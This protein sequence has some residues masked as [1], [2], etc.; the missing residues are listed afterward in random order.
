MWTQISYIAIVVAAVTLCTPMDL[1]IH[2]YTIVYCTLRGRILKYDAFLSLKDVLIFSSSADLYV[3][4][5]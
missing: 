2:I 4:Q 3:M 1:P 5:P